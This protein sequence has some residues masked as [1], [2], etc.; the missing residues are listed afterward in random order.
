VKR[1]SRFSQRSRTVLSGTGDE[2]L[3]SERV[4]QAYLGL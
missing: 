2:I 4:R 3:A 1:I